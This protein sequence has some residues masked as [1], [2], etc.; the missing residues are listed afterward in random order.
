MPSAYCPGHITCIFRPCA[1][2]EETD[3]L[4]IGS[5]GVGIRISL[6]AEATLE[7]RSDGKTII[8]VDGEEGD[9][10][11]SRAAMARMLPG[12]GFELTVRNGA[13]TGQGFGMSAAGAVAAALCAAE[14]KGE[15]M[16]AAYVS[17]HIAELIGGGGLG[18][19]S[20]ITCPAHV[21]VRVRPGLPPDGEVRGTGIKLPKLALAV[22]GPKMNTGK[23]L[24]NPANYARIA[25]AGISC[26]EAFSADESGENL[27]RQSNAFSSATGIEAPEVSSAVAELNSAGIPAAMCM[28]GNSIVAQCGPDELSELLGGVPAIGCSSTGALPHITRRG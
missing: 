10:P 23:I 20:A 11:V 5:V 3:L 4:K 2:S 28:L 12:R 7:E 14:L 9:F 13:P 17:A 27:F 18:D 25:A 1:G 24:V 21:P 16:Q 8:T 19:V 26:L 15:T 22:L 6:G